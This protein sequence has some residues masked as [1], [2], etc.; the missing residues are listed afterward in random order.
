RQ[1]KEHRAR[2]GER[3]RLSVRALVVD[4]RRDL[5]VRR[6]GEELGLELIAGA[7]IDR[8]HTVLKARLLEHDVDL[9]PVGRR[10]G[11]KVDHSFTSCFPKFLP[12]SKSISPRGAFSSPCT[13][14]SLYL[15]RP[16]PK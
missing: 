16:S 15:S 14:D 9:V 12:E 3:E 5:V 11:I 13:I 2:L 4:H 6:D 8:M 7:D 10:P 1:V